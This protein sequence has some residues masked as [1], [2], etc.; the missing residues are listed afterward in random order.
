[1]NGFWRIAHGSTIVCL[2][3]GCSSFR[4]EMGRPL[5]TQRDSFT[6][7]KTR[8]GTVIHDLGPPNRA[9]Q[10]P[11]GFV[12][13]YEYTCVKEFQLGL[14]VPVGFLRYFKFVH[15]WNNLDQQAAM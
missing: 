13:L 6:E 14:S 10:L 5:P 9:S 7:G 2:L 4:T 3:G 8:V 1:M 11:D 12:F 15:A